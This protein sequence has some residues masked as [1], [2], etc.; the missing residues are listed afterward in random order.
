MGVFAEV[1]GELGGGVPGAGDEA[2]G[3]SVAPGGGCAEEVQA[4]DRCLE[5]W[6]EDWVAAGCVQVGGQFGGEEV[7]FGDVD[8]VAGAEDDVVGVAVGG[9]VEFEAY[10]GGGVVG[11]G[12]GACGGEGHVGEA[13]DEPAG[14]GG[15]DRAVGELGLEVAGEP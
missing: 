1:V 10:A 8:L 11:A 12:D 13:V 5:A 6:A 14:S 9:V 3:W 15:S 4:G 2:H 7:V